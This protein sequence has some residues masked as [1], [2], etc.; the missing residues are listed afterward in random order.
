MWV[1]QPL[2]IGGAAENGRDQDLAGTLL[3]E[4]LAR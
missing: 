3:P 2:G 4:A 1:L